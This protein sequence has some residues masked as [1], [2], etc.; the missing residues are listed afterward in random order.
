M[1]DRENLVVASKTRAYIKSKECMMSADA[2]E[3]L[4]KRVYALLDEA[5]KRTRSNKRST[6]K[7]HDF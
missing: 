5:M 1:S 6:I 3:E 2:L 4:N 7:A